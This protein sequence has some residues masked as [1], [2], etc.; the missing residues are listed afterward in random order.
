[1][2]FKC[3]PAALHRGCPCPAGACF[4]AVG[5][6]QWTVFKFLRERGCPGVENYD[7]DGERV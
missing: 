3:K 2:P 7:S 1:L 6:C 5:N 4:A